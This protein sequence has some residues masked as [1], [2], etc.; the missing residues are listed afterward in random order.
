MAYQVYRSLQIFA[1]FEDVFTRTH[2]VPGG[3]SRLRRV[4]AGGA[5][6]VWANT[7]LL[8]EPGA[9]DGID[10]FAI[11]PYFGGQAGIDVNQ[12]PAGTL[13]TV[14][15]LLDML[16]NPADPDNLSHSDLEQRL[17]EI[18]NTAA[19]LAVWRQQSGRQIDLVAYESGQHLVGAG[20]DTEPHVLPLFQAANAHHRMGDMYRRLYLAWNHFGGSEINHFVHREKWWSAGLF[21]ALAWYD[22]DET[23]PG[24]PKYQALLEALAGAA[25]F[26]DGFES[27][28][29]LAWLTAAPQR[30][31]HP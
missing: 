5:G 8:N 29:T 6:Q 24:R 1:I 17:R 4:L 23:T 28:D 9:V 25:L 15:G 14:D 30:T 3:M 16:D 27:G 7:A 20:Y 2:P 19:L 31:A 13:P 11:A 21:G 26:C 12:M 22:E 10:A 18:A